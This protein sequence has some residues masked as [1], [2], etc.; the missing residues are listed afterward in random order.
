MGLV[1]T[2]IGSKVARVFLSQSW[3]VVMQTNYSS[4]LKWKPL[5]SHSQMRYCGRHKVTVAWRPGPLVETEDNWFLWFFF[6][7]SSTNVLKARNP[8][9]LF[10]C[11]PHSTQL[12]H[13]VTKFISFTLQIFTANNTF[14]RQKHKLNQV[15]RFVI[16]TFTWHVDRTNISV[17]TFSI[18]PGKWHRVSP[19]FSRPRWYAKV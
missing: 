8:H 15:L 1:L 18:Y 6:S 2:L 9:S 7:R 16:G 13:L 3:S 12:F 10:S 19:D 4:T 5:C 17:I 14:E 11:C